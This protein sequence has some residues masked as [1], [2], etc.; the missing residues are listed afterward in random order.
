MTPVAPHWLPHAVLGAVDGCITSFVVVS[1]ALGGGFGREAI[2]VLGFANLLADGLSMG[3]SN[4]Q[5]LYG[6][7]NQRAVPGGLVTYAGFVLGGLPPLLPALMGPVDSLG[8]SALLAALTFLVIGYTQGRL[9]HLGV[10]RATTSLLATGLL[11]A[12]VAFGVGR[13]ASQL[14]AHP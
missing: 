12:T 1:G 9:T 5:A 14:V 2:L 10:V 8:P 7:Q 4:F 13:L 3:V 6:Q 11:A